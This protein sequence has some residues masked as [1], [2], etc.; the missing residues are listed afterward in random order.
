T[1]VVVDVVAGTSAGGINGV[2]LAKALA[3]DRSQDGLRDLWFTRGDMN[4]LLLGPRWLTWKIRLPL[5]L[6]LGLKRSPVRGGAMANWLY[7]ALEGMDAEP[8]EQDAL[9]S[10]MP[11]GN[12]LELFVTITDFYGYQREVP[13]STPT[14]VH[15]SRHRHALTF[16]YQV[17]GDDQFEREWNG[18]LAFAARTTSSFPGVFPPV[19]FEA[20]RRWV[21]DA[22]LSRLE[23]RGFRLYA[24]A[25]ADPKTT[26]LVDG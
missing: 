15:D 17:D 19:S 6:P 2:Y 26:Q 21:P 12:A 9:P 22:D 20:F 4:Q 7:Q 11:A 13:I 14:L 18:A 8:D 25:G 3:H 16:G 10:L 23:K 24:L 1:R 5:L